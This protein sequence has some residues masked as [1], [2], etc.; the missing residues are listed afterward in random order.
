[1][2]VVVTIGDI[3]TM[4]GMA[5]SLIAIVIVGIVYLIQNII[6]KRRGKK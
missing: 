5:V 2:K 3:I 6:E 4:I 1:M